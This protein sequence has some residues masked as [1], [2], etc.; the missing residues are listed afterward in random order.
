M[1][2]G[3]Y[4][5]VVSALAGII[6]VGASF[7]VLSQHTQQPTERS[8]GSSF[9]AP[10]NVFDIFHRQNDTDTSSVSDDPTTTEPTETTQDDRAALN[11]LARAWSDRRATLIAQYGVSVD[12]PA[13]PAESTEPQELFTTLLGPKLTDALKSTSGRT[14]TNTSVSFTGESA[15]W[16]GTA[17]V[18]PAQP[19]QIVES[20]YTIQKQLHDYGNELGGA[21]MAFI[22][23]QGDQSATLSLYIDHR[24]DAV[25]QQ[26]LKALT[27]AYADFSQTLAGMTAPTPMASTHQNLVTGYARIG[28]EL[29]KI[30]DAQTDGDLYNK[31]IAYN[32]VA[33]DVTVGVGVGVG[34][35]YGG[36]IARLLY[37]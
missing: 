23:S 29:Y 21:L 14:A 26:K 12:T 24:T 22:Q 3:V 6:I 31:L 10:S 27:D 35:T 33:E 4:S 5:I 18:A 2:M 17:D 32:T 36:V 30:T 13:G 16:G 25:A 11:D 9:S 7:I 19:V 28:T 37:I 8:R 20:T 34:V 15:L 1:H